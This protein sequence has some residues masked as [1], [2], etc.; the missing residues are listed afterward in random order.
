MT[1]K[2]KST[3]LTIVATLIILT[4][5]G[6]R[7]NEAQ[8][9]I[10]FQITPSLHGVEGFKT[11]FNYPQKPNFSD[12]CYNITPPDIS[13]RYGFDIFKF[14]TSC[15]SFLL[16]E[17]KIYP[18]GQCLGGNGVTSF[19][20]AD[21]NADGAFELFFTYSWG[22]G[23]HHSYVG[24]FDSSTKEVIIFDFRILW[25]ELMLETK[26]NKLYVYTASY[27]KN[28]F[29]DIEIFPKDKIAFI[30]ENSGEISLI[31]EQK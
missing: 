10:T 30:I 23:L 27:H 3:L 21:L 22:S 5:I 1:N 2:M 16:Y 4:L 15:G 25:R 17:N 13:E 14:N 29:V 11:L 28:S 20:V 9:I 19:A 6:C 8:E 18:L 26:H 7:K 31:P 24:Y 12:T